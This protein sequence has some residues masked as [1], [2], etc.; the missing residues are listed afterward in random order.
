MSTALAPACLVCGTVLDGPLG[1]AFQIVGIRRNARN[2]NL[3]SRCGAHLEEGRIVEMTVLFA[4]LTSFTEMTSELGPDRTFDIIN[5]FFQRANQILTEED[6]F[7]DKYIGDAVMAIFNAPIQHQNHAQKAVAAAN[8][9]QE[10][11]TSLRHQFGLDLKARIGVATGFARVGRVGSADR[12]DY[13]AIGDVVNLASR[14]EALADPGDVLVD[15]RAYE[16]IRW[17]YPGIP[18]EMLAVRGFKDPVPTHRLN[19]P[20]EAPR[21]AHVLGAGEDLDAPR[22]MGAG[23]VLFAIL[24]APCAATAIL[25][26]L[27]VVLGLGSVM[28]SLAPFLMA[29]DQ[30]P[31]RLTVQL[32]AF[33]GMAVNLYVIWYGY[34]KRKKAGPEGGALALT[35][36]ERRRVWLVAGLALVTLAVTAGEVYS[37]IVLM[38]EK[39]I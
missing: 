31:I 6:A 39:L 38:G 12:K 1:K 34:R 27:A 24:G 25:S 33:A 21:P 37:H 17:E 28:G 13:T 2:P 5:A 20:K 29:L 23:S 18:A 9:L 14:L 7:I 16:Q 32:L 30:S 11:V 35:R 8:R 3:C 4:D 22:M 19:A 10:A 15:G 36:L 26:P